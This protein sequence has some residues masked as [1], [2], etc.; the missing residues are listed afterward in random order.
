MHTNNILV[1]EQYGFREGKCTGNSTFKI[2]D[3]VLKSINQEM[4]VGGILCD[5]AKA[6]ECVNNEI[7]LA[8]LHYYSIQGT[9][10]NCFR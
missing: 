9:V 6:F 4:H 3:S 10:A 7:L 5:L 2:T 8:K 1:L